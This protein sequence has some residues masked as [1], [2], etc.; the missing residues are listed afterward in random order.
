MC[1]H[2]VVDFHKA[3]CNQ[4]IEPCI[5]HFLYHVLVCIFVF[6]LGCF[7]LNYAY[8]FFTLFHF[9][10]VNGIRLFRSNIIKFCILC[11]LGQSIF[12]TFLCYTQQSCFI[13]NVCNQFIS[14]PNREILYGCLI[15]YLRLSTFIHINH[16]NGWVIKTQHS[17]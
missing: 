2:I 16:L 17:Q 12:Y 6:Q 4:S 3:Y 1:W 15:H 5:C 7:F 11:R 9:F 10:T 14:R 8:Q 13:C